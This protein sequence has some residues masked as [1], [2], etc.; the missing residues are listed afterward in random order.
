MI[1]YIH[2]FFSTHLNN[3]CFT[4]PYPT[5]KR[6]LPYSD[7]LSL[8]ASKPLPLATLLQ[9]YHSSWGRLHDILTSIHISHH[10]SATNDTR[11]NCSHIT[12][13]QF[14]MAAHLSHARTRNDRRIRLGIRISSVVRVV[15]CQTFLRWLRNTT[16]TISYVLPLERTSS[17]S[18]IGCPC[19][20]QT[21]QD[22]RR[23]FIIKYLTFPFLVCNNEITR[24]LQHTL[25]KLRM[26]CNL[27][28]NEI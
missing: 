3:L 1:S 2:F 6:H 26:P 21:H 20:S 18:L 7:P 5:H 25:H 16:N 13:H 4:P 14:T 15:L 24:L 8:I 23:N 28:Q 11:W 12:H 9:V 17:V 27:N 19:I 10:N 22:A